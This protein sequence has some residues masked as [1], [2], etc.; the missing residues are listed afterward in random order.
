MVQTGRFDEVLTK[1]LNNFL[2]LTCSQFSTGY[3]RHVFLSFVVMGICIQKLHMSLTPINI[4]FLLVTLISGALIQGA[5]FLFTSVPNFWLIKA[6]SLRTLMWEFKGFIQYP[7]S[8]YVRRICFLE[9]GNKPLSEHR[10]IRRHSYGSYRS[11]R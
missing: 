5:A 4:F 7:I 11:C 2:Y 1:P 6:D 3:V 8:I 9:I 10:F